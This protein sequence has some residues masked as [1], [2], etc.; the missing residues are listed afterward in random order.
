MSFQN[1]SI[2]PRCLRVLKGQRIDEP[3]PVQAKAIPPALDGR[4]VV[5][6]AQT[7]TGK[8]LAFGLPALTQLAK[9][10]KGR[11]RMLVLTPTRELAI[12][13]HDVLQTLGKQ[14]NLSSV[15]VY[16]GVG[17]QPQA[18][19]LRKGVDIVVACPGRL[20]DHINRSNACFDD[21]SI[22]VLDEAD[23]MLDMG[24]LPDIKRILKVLP[25]ERQ[26]MMFSATFPKEIAKLAQDFQHD[27]V[28]IEVARSATPA[29]AVR[30]NVYTVEQKGKLNLLT[31]LLKEGRVDSAL[32]FLRTKYRTERIAKQLHQAGFKAQA[33]HGGRTQ[34]QRQR[35]LDGF[36]K[37]RYNILVATDVA[38]RGLDINGITHVFNFD[39]PNC[40]DDY[41]HRIGRT[42]RANADGDAI[43]F[44]AP[45]DH[46]ALG[47]IERALGKSLPREAWDGAVPVCSA[48]QSHRKGRSDKH[49]QGS[50]NGNGNDRRRR[51]KRSHSRRGHNAQTM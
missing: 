27:P 43:T 2:D 33:I 29:D 4:D 1:Y 19:A 5:A 25:E 41:I 3:T 51:A 7:G 32:V 44:V 31:R 46:A 40:S 11:N 48:F 17:I 38:A 36:R 35:A 15:A 12:Q 20:L 28:R 10:K 34:G 37:G 23:R 22:L 6:V 49:N 50:R 8:T 39:I 47:V 21:L 16:G 18:Q 9:A 13:V 42:A 26:T 14:M 24:F 30:Q 45:E